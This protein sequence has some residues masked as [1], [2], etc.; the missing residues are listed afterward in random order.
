M[1]KP[2][3]GH[4]TPG[5]EPGL[6][7][8]RRGRLKATLTIDKRRMVVAGR[9]VDTIV[10]NG[11]FP[12]PTLVADPGDRMDIWLVSKLDEHARLSCAAR[13]QFRQRVP[14]PRAG[15][16]VRLPLRSPAQA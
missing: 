3:W 6:I 8:S 2:A 16:D 12:G 5:F 10:Y 15:L 13:R 1:V 9:E 14:A 11:G 4:D 7:E